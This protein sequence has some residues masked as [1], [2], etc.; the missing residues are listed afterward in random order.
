MSSVATSPV[1]VTTLS[2]VSTLMPMPRACSSRISRVFTSAVVVASVTARVKRS[3]SGSR[4]SRAPGSKG[5]GSMG[6]AFRV[7]ASGAISRSTW[8]SSTPLVFSAMSAASSRL[9]SLSTAPNR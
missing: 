2:W 3:S 8:T 7:A 6:C 5:S 4:R 9:M 1:S